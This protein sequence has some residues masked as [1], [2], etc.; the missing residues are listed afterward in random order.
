M[1]GSEPKDAR[2]TLETFR[3]EIDEIDAALMA[4]VARRFEIVRKVGVLKA[5]S[6]MEV[7]QSARA[8][9]VVERAGKRAAEAHVSPALME[10]FYEHMID[11]AHEIEHEIVA[12]MAADKDTP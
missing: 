7:V 3:A 12:Q 8:Q 5:R 2:L 11:I 4:L 10:R 6:G 1:S 9:E